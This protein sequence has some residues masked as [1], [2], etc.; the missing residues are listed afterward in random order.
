[1]KTIISS[2]SCV[3]SLGTT[4]EEISD[5]IYNKVSVPTHITTRFESSYK[6]DY[7]VYLV[8]EKLLS[9]KKEDES[10]GFLFV[11]TCVEQALQQAKL[12]KQDLQKYR[13]GIILGTSVNASFN[14][15]DFYKEY[16]KNEVSSY[17]DLVDYFSYSL[18]ERLQN[19][20]SISGLHATITTACASSTDAVGVASQW[21]EQNLCDIVICG[22]T[23]ELNIIPYT[24]FIKLLIAGKNP[25][26]PFSKN[27]GGINI[28]E[29]CGILVLEKEEIFKQRNMEPAGYVLGYGNCCDGYHPTTPAPNGIG[30]KNAVMQAMKQANIKKEELAFI[31]AHG[32]GTHDNDLTESKVFNELLKDVPVMASKSHTGHTLGAAG[33]IEA[34]LSLIAL[35][36]KEIPKAANFKEFDEEINFVPVL[37]N[38]K[39]EKHVAL[40]DSLAFGGVN[41]VIILGDKNA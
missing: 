26:S 15:F 31:N 10:Y 37:Q 27:R 4:L 24:G 3:C 5:N 20:L 29:G 28:G 17:W 19:Y 2:M 13:V 22:G 11:R 9:Q 8:P 14:C 30:L 32:T 18:S 12:S 6:N 33:A 40:S 23:D 1:M 39:T 35:N 25:C 7:P 36:K 34:V 21:I 16:K 41:S 38:T